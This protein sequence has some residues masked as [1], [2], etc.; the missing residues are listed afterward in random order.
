MHLTKEPKLSPSPNQLI[1]ET[2]SQE[3]TFNI[4]P[5]LKHVKI[6]C[7]HVEKKLHVDAGT[8][9][10]KDLAQSLSIYM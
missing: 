7:G 5:L 8:F 2:M 1:L 6:V 3:N 10:Y 9:L 4:K